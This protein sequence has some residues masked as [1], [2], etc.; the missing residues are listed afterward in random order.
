MGGNVWEW[1]ADWYDK[2]YYRQN[3]RRNPKGPS[4]GDGKV[5]RGGSWAEHPELTRSRTG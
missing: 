1:V 3:A 5:I 4:K 2:G